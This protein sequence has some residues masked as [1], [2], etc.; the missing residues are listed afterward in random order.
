MIDFSKRIKGT[1]KPEDYGIQIQAEFV[2]EIGEYSYNH[3]DY[4]NR[5]VFKKYKNIFVNICEDNGG[6]LLLKFTGGPTGHECYFL[7]DILD[8]INRWENNESDTFCICGGTI[9]RWDA[10]YVSRKEVHKFIMEVMGE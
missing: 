9:N 3:K 8:D 5:K 4:L 10:C 2:R 1:R 7:Q 6:R